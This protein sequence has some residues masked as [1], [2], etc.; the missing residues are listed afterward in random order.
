MPGIMLAGTQR[1]TVA[2]ATRKSRVVTDH[3]RGSE[4]LTQRLLV[5]VAL[6]AATW[7]SAA[8]LTEALAEGATRWTW[9][10]AVA[11]SSSGTAVT[12]ASA[13]VAATTATTGASAVATTTS[14]VSAS[15]AIA[16]PCARAGA[17]TAATLIIAKATGGGRT[18][19]LE[20]GLWCLAW[21]C[22]YA[23]TAQVGSVD[24]L[25]HLIGELGSDLHE[26]D[27]GQDLDATD[28]RAIHA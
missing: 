24:G 10:S 27:G 20:L 15:A 13:A 22:A 25:E 9:R 21:G 23:A 4:T 17:V 6:G 26:R 7:R 19:T 14:C 16:T 1:W 11:P 5:E 3:T 18:T 28:G 8:A 2:R 12:A